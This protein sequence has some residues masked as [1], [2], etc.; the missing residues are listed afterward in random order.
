[1]SA[2]LGQFHLDGAPVDPHQFQKG[3]DALA[4]YAVE[5]SGRWIEGLIGLGYSTKDAEKAV[6]TVAGA[7]GETT[8]VGALLRAALQTLRKG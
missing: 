4:H 1:M 3:M 7:N 8:D 5:R 2:I 6:E